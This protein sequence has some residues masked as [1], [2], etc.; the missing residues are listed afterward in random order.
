[1]SGWMEE[2]P[3]QEKGLELGSFPISLPRILA[4]EAEGTSV[5]EVGLSCR[6]EWHWALCLLPRTWSPRTP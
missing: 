2:S 3:S 1:M 5:T 6:W 4:S